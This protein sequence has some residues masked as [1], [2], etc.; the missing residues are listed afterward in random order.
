MLIEQA[1]EVNIAKIKASALLGLLKNKLKRGECPVFTS[2]SEQIKE[3]SLNLP[4]SKKKIFFPF[5]KTFESP[6]Q[7]LNDPYDENRKKEILE[8]YH[9]NIYDDSS[10]INF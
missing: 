10:I 5:S 7:L 9:H 8:I 3:Y 1:K 6:V 4:S 2:Y